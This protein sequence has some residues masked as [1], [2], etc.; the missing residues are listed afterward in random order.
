MFFQN[1]NKMDLNEHKA[2]HSHI[3]LPWDENYWNIK[4]MH[5]VSSSEVFATLSKNA[6]SI[7]LFLSVVEFNKT[8]QQ[9]FR[10]Y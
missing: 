6:V 8:F 9:F 2:M 4:V 7:I 3:E 5:I 1:N 10:I